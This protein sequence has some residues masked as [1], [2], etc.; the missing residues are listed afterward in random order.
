MGFGGANL[1]RWGSLLLLLFATSCATA[2]KDWDFPERPASGVPLDPA[3]YCADSLSQPPMPGRQAEGL[4]WAPRVVQ[5]VDAPYP[6]VAVLD[7][8][9]GTVRLRMWIATTGHIDE[10]VVVE[11]SGWR[12]L[13][14]AAIESM[15]RSTFAPACSPRGEPVAASYVSVRQF[16]VRGR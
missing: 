12:D 9:E 3:R 6:T 4:R 15:R 10:I 7:G 13:D 11:S 14:D 2:T 1:A 5:R 8:R 16:S